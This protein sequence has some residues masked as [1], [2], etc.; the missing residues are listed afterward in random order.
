MGIFADPKLVF[1][2]KVKV[3]SGFAWMSVTGTAELDINGDGY[4]DYVVARHSFPTS[5]VEIRLEIMLGQ[6]NGTFKSGDT[7]TFK[8]SLPGVIGSQFISVGDFNGDGHL[9]VFLPEYG[10]D[11]D[12]LHGTHQHAAALGRWQAQEGSGRVDPIGLQLRA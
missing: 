9:D 1:E 5:Q 8:G 2:T 12:S 10:I 11:A 6:K 3:P 4:L 7:T